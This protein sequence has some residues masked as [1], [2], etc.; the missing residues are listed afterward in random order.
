MHEI[1][2][3]PDDFG[4]ILGLVPGVAREQFQIGI[5]SEG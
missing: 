4:E 2:T 5:A 1:K 3:A